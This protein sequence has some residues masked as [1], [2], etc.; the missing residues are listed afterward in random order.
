MGRINNLE[1]NPELNKIFGAVELL[2]DPAEY[3]KEKAK[4]T[5]LFRETS[6][7]YFQINSRK[8]EFHNFIYF[9]ESVLCGSGYKMIED[10]SYPKDVIDKQIELVK[11]LLGTKYLDGAENDTTDRDI[12]F[13]KFLNSK[14]T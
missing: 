3:Q 14:K 6:N 12:E 7:L 10:S 8:A 11:L 4:N 13:Q 1:N 5:Q 9:S 2:A